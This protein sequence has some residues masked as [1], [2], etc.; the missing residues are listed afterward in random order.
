MMEKTYGCA[1]LTKEEAN[2]N[3]GYLELNPDVILEEWH[4]NR[5]MTNELWTKINDIIN[6]I[7]EDVH[8]LAKLHGNKVMKNLLMH[9]DREDWDFIDFDCL[10]Q[11]YEEFYA[12]RAVGTVTS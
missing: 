5:T 2:L 11:A 10:I 12:I 4:D 7:C 1:G 8:R 6:Y 9:F 3:S